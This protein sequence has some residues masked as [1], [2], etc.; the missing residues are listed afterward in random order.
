MSA[1]D[2]KRTLTPGQNVLTTLFQSAR[3][4]DHVVLGFGNDYVRRRDFTIREFATRPKATAI[5]DIPTI[6]YGA[7]VP[8]RIVAGTAAI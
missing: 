6:A 7:R 8:V 1:F 2:P 3:L 5:P 4:L